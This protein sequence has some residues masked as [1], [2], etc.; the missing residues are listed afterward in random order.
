MIS[1]DEAIWLRELWEAVGDFHLFKFT[2]LNPPRLFPY[3]RIHLAETPVE[4]LGVPNLSEFVFVPHAGKGLSLDKALGSAVGEA[5]ERVLP[6]LSQPHVVLASYAE[7]GEEALGPGSIHLFAEEQYGTIPYRRFLPN[8]RVGWIA[9]RDLEGRRVLIP[10]Q[11][12][13]FG[14]ILRKGETPIA[15][16]HSGGLASGPSKLFAIYRGVVEFLERD[17]INIGW[18][19]D[20]PP[21]RLKMGLKEALD[22]LG[23]RWAGDYKL[24]VFLWPSDVGVVVISAHLID[25]HR[26]VYN[27][28]P[29]CGAGLSIEEALE[30]ALGEVA[31][32]LDFKTVVTSGIL[33]ELYYVD[34]DAPPEAA[35][36]LFRIVYY[37]GYRENLEKL[38]AEFFSRAKEA[39]PP[40]VYVAERLSHKFSYLKTALGD[41]KFYVVDHKHPDSDVEIAK[42]FSPDFTQYNSPRLPMLGHPRY[43][44]PAPGITRTY[45]ELRKKPVPYP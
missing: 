41:A 42:V 3:F 37:Y 7:L 25:P 13:R 40:K 11:I 6:L 20:I 33:K 18:H 34:K 35:D 1:L 45:A 17:A 14:Y 9:A 2:G 23:W 16:S 12:G 15:Y 24:H 39:D 10:A 29:G 19:S 4:A 21:K 22:I 43:Y 31:Q 8:T 5:F 32:A 44:N 26:D 38:Y 36:N 30:R 28:F 27:Y